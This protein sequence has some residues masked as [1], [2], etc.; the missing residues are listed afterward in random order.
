MAAKI[1]TAQEMTLEMLGVQ[2]GFRA[3]WARELSV[4]VLD[5]NDGVLRA[6]ACCRCSRAAR[7][8]G[9]DASAALAA[10]DMSR[11]FALG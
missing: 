8:T 9:Q 1:R 10:N 11:L 4:S 2:V 5:R 3:V 7:C 6:T